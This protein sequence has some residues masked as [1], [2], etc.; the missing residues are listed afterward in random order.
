MWCCV[1]VN[2]NRIAV[3]AEDDAMAE[4]HV[5]AIIKANVALKQTALVAKAFSLVNSDKIDAAVAS[6]LK[7]NP[8]SIIL[9]SLFKFAIALIRKARK[10]GYGGQFLTFLVVGFGPF[11]FCI[12]ER[13]RQ[14]LYIPS[15]TVTPQRRG[16]LHREIPVWLKPDRS[17]AQLRK[18]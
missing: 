12:R 8:H 15:D 9:V 1:T 16:T 10:P 5:A 2:Q 18:C 14:N 17:N 6:L 13:N 4:A 7:A 3:F 11:F